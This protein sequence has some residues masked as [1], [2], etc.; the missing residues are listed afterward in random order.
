MS[1]FRPSVDFGWGLRGL[2]SLRPK[3]GVIV[4][5]DV[6]SFSTAVDVATSRGAQILPF[7]YG[8][9]DAEGYARSRGAVLA[10]PRRAGGGQLSLSPGT[11]KT[12]TNGA[13]IVLPS[14]NG[15]RAVSRNGRDADLCRL[16]AQCSGC[17]TGLVIAGPVHRRRSRGRAL[18]RRQ[19]ASGDRGPP[20]GGGDNSRHAGAVVSGCG[21]GPR[22]LS[23]ASRPAPECHPGVAIRPGAYRGGLRRRCGDRGPNERKPHG[24][25]SAP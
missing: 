13:R 12:V 10:R 9:S 8:H 3:S 19:L 20:W 18:A 21:S 1:S 17:R 2:L 16:P 7:P 5:V 14:P 11:L 23:C 25:V 24:A 4:I 22:G 6:L 15:S